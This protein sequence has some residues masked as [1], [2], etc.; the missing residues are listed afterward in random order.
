MHKQ[1]SSASGQGIHLKNMDSKSGND[2]TNECRR[3]IFGEYS[4]DEE[5]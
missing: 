4:N 2:V 3:G 5:E 1:I